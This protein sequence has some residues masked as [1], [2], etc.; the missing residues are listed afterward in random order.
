MRSRWERFTRSVVVL[1]PVPPAL[2]LGVERL[3]SDGREAPSQA[4][5]TMLMALR[6][7]GAARV[8]IRGSRSQRLVRAVE[9]DSLVAHLVSVARVMVVA[10]KVVEVADAMPEAGAKVSPHVVVVAVVIATQLAD[11]AELALLA[12]ALA[13]AALTPA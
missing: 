5:P 3:E 6:P 13:R 2:R 12:V 11:R 4:I 8:E 10:A 1:R 7:R 9:L